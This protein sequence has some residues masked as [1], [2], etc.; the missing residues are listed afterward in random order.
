MTHRKAF[1]T[2]RGRLALAQCVVEHGWTF[3]RAADRF[4]CS[5]A[6]ARNGPTAT[7]RA[8]KRP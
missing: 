3:R 1:L 8:V 2:P 6:M 7:A 5:A 4:N